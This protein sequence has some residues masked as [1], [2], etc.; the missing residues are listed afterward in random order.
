MEDGEGKRE[1]GK[2]RR[3]N[4]VEAGNLCSGDDILITRREKEKERKGEK[5]RKELIH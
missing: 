3:E 4:G 2:G 5:K 1:K